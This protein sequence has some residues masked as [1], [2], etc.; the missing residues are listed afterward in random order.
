[1]KTGLDLI[2][3]R[4]QL[5][6]NPE[7]VDKLIEQ[8]RDKRDTDSIRMWLKEQS[9]IQL[10]TLVGLIDLERQDRYVQKNL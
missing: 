5:K 1:M 9:K 3:Y 10:E 7:M 2:E 6:S 8:M 4:E